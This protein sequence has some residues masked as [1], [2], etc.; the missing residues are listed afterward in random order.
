MSHSWRVP[1]LPGLMKRVLLFCVL[2]SGCATHQ[3]APRIISTDWATV[4]ALS[5]GTEVAVTVTDDQVRL[6]EVKSVSAA[7]ITLREKAGL[8]IV[9]RA[10][11]WRVTVREPAGVNRWPLVVQTAAIGAAV[12][13][14]PAYLATVN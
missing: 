1:R 14:V 13:A 7:A 11:I 5:P 9:S 10:E 2:L 8:R 6:G 4:E 3:A 12:A